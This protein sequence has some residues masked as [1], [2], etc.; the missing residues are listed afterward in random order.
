MRYL[1]LCEYS[2]AVAISFNV[3][4][5]LPTISNGRH[6]AAYILSLAVVSVFTAITVFYYLKLRDRVTMN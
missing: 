6:A 5:V 2:F 3:T 1:L 4:N